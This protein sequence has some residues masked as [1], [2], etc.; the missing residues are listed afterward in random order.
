MDTA[1][2]SHFNT[3]A[4]AAKARGIGG[5]VEGVWA[6]YNLRAHRRGIRQTRGCRA[7]Y[8]QKV[9]KL[10]SAKTLDGGSLIIHAEDGGVKVNNVNVLMTNIATQER[11]DS[12]DGYGAPARMTVT[13]WF[14]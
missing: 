12:R 7:G 5:Y 1:V 4:A 3:L 9:A 14:F 6:V 13:A 2:A 11:L 8:A 10:H